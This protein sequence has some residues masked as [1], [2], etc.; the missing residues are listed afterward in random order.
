MSGWVTFGAS[1][2][3]GAVAA[4]AALGAVA[5]GQRGENS[6]ASKADQQWLRDRKGERLRHLYEPFVEFG[7]LLQQVAREKAYVLP[8]DT[9]D[10]RDRRHQLQMTEGM[11][12]V[13]TVIA[14]TVIEPG[15]SEVRTAYKS[16]YEACD[17][18][19]RSLTMIAQVPGSTSLDDLK[20][21][22]EAISAAADTL[23]STVLGQLE[24]LEK[25]I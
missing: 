21:Q 19:L 3:G 8:G 15:T 1:V 5:L 4:A 17:K 10:D 7:L 6:R 9:V 25:P 18:Y 16:T 12:R 20:K 2:V 13:S 14:A 22:F 23:Q 11:H 24:E